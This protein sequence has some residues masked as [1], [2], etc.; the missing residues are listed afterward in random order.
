MIWLSNPINANSGK[1]TSAMADPMLPLRGLSPVS[2][3]TIV[4]RF[5]GGMLSSALSEIHLC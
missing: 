1:T 3:K 5:D 4:A 2:G